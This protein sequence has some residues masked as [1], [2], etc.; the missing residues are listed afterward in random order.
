MASS[1][2]AMNPATPA[3]SGEAGASAVHSAPMDSSAQLT[4]SEVSVVLA[5]V[6][7]RWV[8]STESATAST[9]SS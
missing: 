6:H 2:A 9:M 1:A 8:R 5:L 4:T 7:G 3:F